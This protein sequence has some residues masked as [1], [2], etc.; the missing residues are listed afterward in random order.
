MN[1]RQF[2]KMLDLAAVAP[3][4]SWATRRFAA[5]SPQMAITIDDF[6]LFGASQPIAEKRNRSLLDALRAHSDLKAAGF[7]C[8]KNIDSDLGK[9]LVPE[10][11]R[12][13]HMMRLS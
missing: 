12:A 7:I 4:S 8:G 3:G 1:R 6:D 10:W 9:S 2:A 13:G 11:S 5:E